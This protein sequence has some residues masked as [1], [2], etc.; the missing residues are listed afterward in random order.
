MDI[1]DMRRKI[2]PILLP[3]G[4]ERVAVFGSY[5]RG[6]EQPES[7]IDL[8]VKFKPPSER[9]P[10]G[11]KWYSLENE[12]ARVLGRRTEMVSEDALSPY[13][14]SSVEDEKVVQDGVIRQLEIIGEASRHVSE[15]LRDQHGEI[16]WPEV[17]SLRNRLIHAYDRVDIRIVWEIVENDL[18]PLKSCAQR[19]IDGGA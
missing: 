7:D 14:K 9:P 10:I 2:L 6:E 12:L 3:Y 18:P 15:T 11:L 8:L 13:V 16:P 19:I 4:L 1:E 5:A 17:I